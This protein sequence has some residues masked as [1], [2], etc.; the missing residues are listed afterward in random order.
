MNRYIN[1]YLV[2][3]L[4]LV[5]LLIT[6]ELLADTEVNIGPCQDLPQVGASIP[7]TYRVIKVLAC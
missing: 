4:R 1:I 7:L 6:T 5:C 3:Y 2:Q